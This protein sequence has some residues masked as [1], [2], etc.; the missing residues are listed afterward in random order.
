MEIS[1]QL[2]SIEVEDL[3]VVNIHGI[4][5]NFTIFPED[6]VELNDEE[7]IIHMVENKKYGR[8]A[9]DITLFRHALMSLAQR[10]RIV[11]FAAAKPGAS[12]AK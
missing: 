6:T 4:Q 3:D 10:K 7:I 5:A 2:T 9:E 11:Q 8:V 12:L 1:S